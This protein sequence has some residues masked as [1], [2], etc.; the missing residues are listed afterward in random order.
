MSCFISK[1][2][3]CLNFFP[4]NYTSNLCCCSLH[5]HALP[6]TCSLKLHLQI[7]ESTPPPT[8]S[9]MTN[10]SSPNLH[11][12]PSAPSLQSPPPASASNLHCRLHLQILAERC[13]TNLN[14]QHLPATCTT[15]STCRLLQI[16]Q[17]QPS[18]H[19]L[20]TN[21]QPLPATCTT[22]TTCRFWQTA[23]VQ[24]STYSHFQFL[25]ETSTSS[26]H[27]LLHLQIVKDSSTLAS[28]LQPLLATCTTPSP[29]GS[30]RELQ[31]ESPP[32][33][34]PDTAQ[35]STSS[36]QFLQVTCTAAPSCRF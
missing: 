10:S 4:A 29:A 26:L 31:S 36:L 2:S 13:S 19:L 7:T 3:F 5:L 11:F 32:T 20:T 12:Q 34:T 6:S 16:V 33:P 28:S 21:F 8:T 27:R 9:I 15:S 24:I 22:P 14:L 17:V 30:G 18:L 25:F 23:I 1:C 35:T